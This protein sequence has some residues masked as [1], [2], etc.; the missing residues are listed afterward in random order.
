MAKLIVLTLDPPSLEDAQRYVDGTVEVITLDTGDQMLV[1]EDGLIYCLEYNIYAS[2]A[3]KRTV[4]GNAM[5]LTGE[6]KWRPEDD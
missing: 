2:R 1:N 5:I 6:A 4:V 3:A